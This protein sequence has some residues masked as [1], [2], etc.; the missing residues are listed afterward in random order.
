MSARLSAWAERRP[1]ADEHSRSVYANLLAD[2]L[3]RP[4]SPP[5]FSDADIDAIKAAHIRRFNENLPRTE[6]LMAVA[7]IGFRLALRDTA[8]PS[9]QRQRVP[10]KRNG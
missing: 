6:T 4:S 10:G 3:P 1:E 5:F 9:P 8:K 2:H 7:M